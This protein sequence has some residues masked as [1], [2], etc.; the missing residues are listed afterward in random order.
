MDQAGLVS[1]MGINK[2]TLPLIKHAL[3]EA[4]INRKEAKLALMGDLVMRHLGKRRANRVLRKTWGE[5]ISF[6]ING[7]ADVL[8]DLCQPIDP[9][10]HAY[11]DMVINGGT[12]EHVENQQMFFDNCDVVVRPGGVLL[13]AWPEIGSFRDHS[14]YGYAYDFR[15]LVDYAI[16]Y[17]YRPINIERNFHGK[18]KGFAIYTT[19]IKPKN[20]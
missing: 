10:Y 18:R 17:G 3:K 1:L 9:K 7:R 8:A 19:L 6:D 16:K 11:F 4:K 2:Y 5:V 14:A 20:P 13:H 15:F 12:A